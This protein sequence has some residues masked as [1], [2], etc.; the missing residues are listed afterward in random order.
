M[1]NNSPQLNSFPVDTREDLVINA[2]EI[3][4]T[5]KQSLMVLNKDLVVV[6]ANASFYSTFQVTRKQTEG[7]RIYDIGNG[8]WDIDKL[9]VLFEKIIP[10]NKAVDD[11]EVSHTFDHIGEKVMLLNAR[12]ILRQDNRQKVILL[13]IEDITRNKQLEQQTKD[14]GVRIN[15][16]L[17]NLVGSAE[18]YTG[19]T[20][21]QHGAEKA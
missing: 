3:F 19:S 5:I 6:M 15:A 2:I 7:K 12:E 1:T 20:A 16:I 13:A 8:Q 9:K 4:D 17:E 14:A 10:E 11:Y 21:P 18:R